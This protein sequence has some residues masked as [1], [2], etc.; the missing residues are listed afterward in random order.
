ML[1]LKVSSVGHRIIIYI[2]EDDLW[3]RGKRKVQIKLWNLLFDF[4]DHNLGTFSVIVPKIGRVSSQSSTISIRTAAAPNI[5]ETAE[6][7]ATYNWEW[8]QKLYFLCIYH[9]TSNKTRI[10]IRPAVIIRLI[11]KKSQFLI[12]PAFLSQEKE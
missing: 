5:V 2:S 4:T 11:S 1:S 7:F 6:L 12:R 9:K 8:L 3:A 10:L